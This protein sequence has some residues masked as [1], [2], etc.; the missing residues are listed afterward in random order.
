MK[1]KFL[2]AH[3]FFFQVQSFQTADFQKLAETICTKW[4]LRL[5]LVGRTE[6]KKGKCKEDGLSKTD[7]KVVYQPS[8]IDPAKRDPWRNEKGKREKK[9]L[10]KKKKGKENKASYI[11]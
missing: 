10:I 9:L 5:C 11:N 7:S 3:F 1:Y 6:S 8:L 2:I 4:A